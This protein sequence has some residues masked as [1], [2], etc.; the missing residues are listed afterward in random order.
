[1]CSKCVAAGPQNV[2]EPDTGRASSPLFF[3][4]RG[5]RSLSL[6]EAG[7][8][9]P[10]RSWRGAERRKAHPSSYCRTLFWRARTPLGAPHAAIS[11]HGPAFP[12]LHPASVALSTAQAQHLDAVS[13]DDGGTG[14]LPVQRSTSRMGRSTQGA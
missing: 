1:K 10:L 11:V 8:L 2:T 5:R 12:G 3:A 14:M 6:P 13:R 7:A 9:F 4:A